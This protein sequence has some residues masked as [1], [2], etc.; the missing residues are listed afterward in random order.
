ME[1]QHKQKF[2]LH[3]P[4][5]LK[6]LA[7]H[8]YSTKNVAIRELIQNAHDSC[9]RR[10]VEQSSSE[11]IEARIHLTIDSASQTLVIS[12]NGSG[13][14][15][16]DIRNYLATIGRS[17]TRELSERLSVLSP[18]EASELIGQF[19]LGFLSAFLIASEISIITLSQQE[20]AQALMWH[21]MGDEYYEVTDAEKADIGTTINIKLK[22]GA[23][24]LLD[25][26]ALARVIRH[27]ADLIPTPI[28]VGDNPAPV[29][30]ST[31]PWKAED[32]ERAARDYISRIFQLD[33]PL[34]VCLL[35]NHTLNLGHDSVELPLNGF[36][37]IPPSSI[38][39]V[40]EYGDIIVYIRRMFITDNERELLPPWARFVQGV[41]DC[42]FLQPTAS[43]E[44][45]HQ[46][47]N[48][49]LVQRALEEQLID[50][51]R[52]VAKNNPVQWKQ[53]VR[54]HS[55]VLM[56]WAVRDN[57]FFDQIADVVTF[58]T[59]RGL[60]SLPEYLSLTSATI[61]FTSRELGSLQEQMLGEGYD[62]PVIDASWFAVE[63]FLEKYTAWRSDLKLIQMDGGSKSLLH[64]VAPEPFQMLLTYY[65]E[66]QINARIATFKPVEVPALILYPRDAELLTEARNAL[67][68]GEISGPM[69][70]LISDYL[71][72]LEQEANPENDAKGIL[73][74]NASS[75]LI[76][77]LAVPDIPK[78]VLPPILNTL[79]QVARL[80]AARTLT[81]VDAAQAFGQIGH[82]L[83]TLIKHDGS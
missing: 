24:Y 33:N 7:E 31:P 23:A 27:Y 78:I 63:P 73:Y 80:F 54:G 44:S 59:S 70:G 72:R 6:V 69:V 35:H 34:G 42:P 9:I 15:E 65:Q 66:R 2:D 77:Q 1:P 57:E 18:Q 60:L 5:L 51:L 12:D 55:D 68:S 13:L 81:P 74:L 52:S 76:Q 64:P 83:Q 53:I 22:P 19:G 40:R 46:D 58:R 62:V 32:H 17:Y 28:Y 30:L 61:Y 8:L 29:N 26:Q 71:N 39:S 41:I 79:Y 56:G 11:Q 37:F 25:E 45:I 48:F 4:G 82:S 38:A 43:R 20:N 3:L 10:T 16:S 21:S 36:L 47:D 14:T 50:W 75:S 67:D 49:E